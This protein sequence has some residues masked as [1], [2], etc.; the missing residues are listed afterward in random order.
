MKRIGVVFE[1]NVELLS[2]EVCGTYVLKYLS[3]DF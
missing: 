1:K 2:G 3:P